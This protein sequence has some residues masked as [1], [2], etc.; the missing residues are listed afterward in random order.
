MRFPRLK[1]LNPKP[2]IA[3]SAE[4]FWVCSGLRVEPTSEVAWH[5]IRAKWWIASGSGCR[6]KVLNLERLGIYRAKAEL[7]K[8]GSASGS[9]CRVKVL[10]FERLGV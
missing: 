5:V 3:C 9:G 6:V 2:E 1:T 4:G 8:L 10:N 7:R